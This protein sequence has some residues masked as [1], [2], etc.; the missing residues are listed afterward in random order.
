[1]RETSEGHQPISAGGSNQNSMFNFPI[2][3]IKIIT[4]HI[5]EVN[6]P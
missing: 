2:Y 1:M 5:S 4:G 6:L 3:K